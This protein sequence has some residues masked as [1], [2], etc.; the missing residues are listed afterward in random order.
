LA[1]VI[2]QALCP[3]IAHQLPT[4]EDVAS[5]GKRHPARAAIGSHNSISPAFVGVNPHASK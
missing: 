5:D 1:T 2:Y 3:L 4:T